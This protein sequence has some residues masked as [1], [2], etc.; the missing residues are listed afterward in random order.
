MVSCAVHFFT[1]VDEILAKANQAL[2]R[3]GGRRGINRLKVV[4]R[5]RS[6]GQIVAEPMNVCRPGIPSRD[7]I[8]AAVLEIKIGRGTSGLEHHRGQF[9]TPA[10]RLQRRVLKRHEKLK[11]FRVSAQCPGQTACPRTERRVTL[12]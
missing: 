4:V 12:L 9:L 5:I 3:D 10:K 8:R 2:R 6:A 1:R 11:L 7:A